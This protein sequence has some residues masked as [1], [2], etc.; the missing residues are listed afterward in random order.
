[1]KI[2]SQLVGL[3]TLLTSCAGLSEKEISSPYYVAQDPAA[4]YKTLYYHCPKGLGCE[5]IR[6]VQRVGDTADYIF[7][8]SISGFYYIIRAQD[9]PSDSGNPAVQKAIHGPLTQSNLRAV[10]ASLDVADFTFQYSAI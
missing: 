8:E 6:N 2:S 5:R 1:M 9:Q 10:M 4:S 3:L 7:I